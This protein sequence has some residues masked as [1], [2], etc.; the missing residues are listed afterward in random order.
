M[1]REPNDEW[2]AAAERIPAALY[3]ELL[4]NLTDALVMVDRHGR[5]VEA[6]PA[7]AAALGYAPAELIGRS[8]ADLLVVDRGL[9]AARRRMGRSGN[10][11]GRWKGRLMLRRRDR[12]LIAFDV[13]LTTFDGS[14]DPLYVAVGRAGDAAMPSSAPLPL[15]QAALEQA[16]DAVVITTAE[17][18]RPGPQIVYVNAA[19]CALTGYSAAELIGRTPRILQ[20][21]ESDRRVLDQVRAKL[22]RGEPTHD[23]LINYRKDGAA[24]FMEWHIAPVRNASGAITHWVSIQRDITEQKEAERERERLYEAA[25]AALSVRDQ[26]LTMV[27]HE[28]KTPLTSLMGYAHL[29]QR[30]QTAELLASERLQQAVKVIVEQAQRL[31]VLIE[32]LLDLSRIQAG[33]LSL[34]RERFDLTALMREVADEFRPVLERHSL[35][36]SAP[37]EPTLISGDMLRLRH[38]LQQLIQNAISYSPRGGPIEV[39]IQPQPEQI[40]LS[41]SD[42]GIGVPAAA[43]KQIFERFYRAGNVNPSQIS[44]FGVGLYVVHEIV[45]RHGGTV[46]VSSAEGQGSTFTICLPRNEQAGEPAAEAGG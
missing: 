11:A 36:L 16:N 19:F 29:L 4:A 24:Y 20:G 43:Q 7:A 18:A 23:E 38:T 17:L 26:L 41:V 42:Q 3:R 34:A 46:S 10:G 14:D 9:A 13:T 1:Q 27:S 31:N 28:L 25:Q 30:H 6:N 35:T 2:Q 44:G 45:T 21:P 39:R 37:D 33:S 12:S 40:C 8:S 32:G 22:S 15:L 5:I